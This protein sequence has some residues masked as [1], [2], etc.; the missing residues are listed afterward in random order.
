M[1]EKDWSL[2]GPMMNNVK[3]FILMKKISEAEHLL[4]PA[5]NLLLQRLRHRPII[6]EEVVVPLMPQRQPVNGLQLLLHRDLRRQPNQQHRL[7]SLQLS[8]L[9]V[10]G[11]ENPSKKNIQMLHLHLHKLLL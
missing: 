5:I 6:A 2:P 11:V 3:D 7:M 4:Q 8:L 10:I 1:T 9:K